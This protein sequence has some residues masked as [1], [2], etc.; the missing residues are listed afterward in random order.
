MRIAVIGGGHGALAAA[1]DLALRG[2][3][4]RLRLRNRERFAEVFG[5]GEVALTGVAGEGV[6]RLAAVT[7]DVAAA[8]RDAE[9]V[10]VPMPATT[11]A[12]IAER[13]A[14]HLPDGVAVALLPGTFGAYVVGRRLGVAVAETA[15]LPYGAR[16]RGGKVVSTA[17]RAHHLP[18]GVYPARDT[19][20]ALAVLAA[21][22]PAVVPVED[23][24]SAAL[25]N[26][27][28]ALHAPL[29]LM[30]AGPIERLGEYDIHVEGTTPGIQAVMAA[31]DGERIALRTAL[32]YT[33]PHWPLMDYYADADWLYGPGAFSTVQRKSVW[34]E[35]L[36]FEHRY[37]TEDVE[38]GLV[39][40]SSL[41]TA[42]GVATPLSD[43]FI[44]LAGVVLGRDL[45]ASGR[46]LAGLG[47][48]G[49]DGAAIRARL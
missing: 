15:T 17:L 40:W 1:A 41:G 35:P 4:V 46:T 23:A 22:Y 20:A 49:L 9:L 3:Q 12:D 39:L 45:R 31:L 25:L 7:D 13:L 19:A 18:A 24:L 47:L 34:R 30:N 37:L 26:S 16:F 42:L 44:E 6:G 5:S 36:G 29:V 43:A 28:G 2:H 27:N 21:A 8:V 48:A 11:Q 32:G 14:G 33:S 10:L 38:L